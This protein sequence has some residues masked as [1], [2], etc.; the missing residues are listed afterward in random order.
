MINIQIL[1]LDP[2]VVGHYSKDHSANL[3]QLF[4]VNEDE[5]SF[6]ASEGMMFHQGVEQTSWDTLVVVRAPEEAHALEDVVSD[7]LLETL[8]QFS[9]NVTVLFEYFHGHHVHQKIN[10]QYPRFIGPDQIEEEEIEETPEEE[11]EEES[12]SCGHHHEHGHEHE[13]EGEEEIDIED[14]ESIYLGNAFEGFE[15]ALEEAYGNQ[16]K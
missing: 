14:E 8:S 15:E 1:G 12:C 11:G 13:H 5:L 9:I 3:A 2:F 7:Y 4:E 6:H 10:T 16:K